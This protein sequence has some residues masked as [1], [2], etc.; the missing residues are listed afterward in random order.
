[1]LKY[2]DFENC[3]NLKTISTEAFKTTKLDGQYYI[4]GVIKLPDGL[5]SIGNSAFNDTISSSTE[6]K[7]YIPASVSSMG[8]Y[9]VANWDGAKAPC[10]IYIGEEEDFS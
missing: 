9:A 2:F 1:M 3:T 10:T 8:Q 7:F 6:I 5:K 4:D